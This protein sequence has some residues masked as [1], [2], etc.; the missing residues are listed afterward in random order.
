MKIID[1]SWGLSEKTAQ[2]I[3]LIYVH[4]YVNIYINKD[5]FLWTKCYECV[6]VHKSSFLVPFNKIILFK[7]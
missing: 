3:F 7:M 1:I 6:Y 5:F 2:N 4:G